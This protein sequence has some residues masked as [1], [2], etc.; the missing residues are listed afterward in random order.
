MRT[1][2]ITGATKGIGLSIAETL[3][4]STDYYVVGVGRSGADIGHLLGNERFQYVECD[5]SS[6]GFENRLKSAIPAELYGIVNNAGICK[7]HF[8]NDSSPDTFDEV[9]SVNLQAP[10]RIV[11]TLHSA[12]CDRGRIVNISS[13][14][15]Q[16]GRAGYSAYCASKFAL[17]GMTKCWAKE[18]GARGITVNAVCPGWVET[19]MGIK[20]VERLAV[21]S[22]VSFDAFYG[23]ICKP[24]ELKRFTKPAEIAEL[25]AFLLSDA[26]SGI[27]GRDWLLNTIWNQE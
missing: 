9:L 8:L 11:K 25:V 16:E 24:L 6:A 26:A 13:Q 22:G 19:E 27:T 17:I 15:G 20:D 12:L 18:L 10:Y 1:I 2:L 23:E 21:E 3:L 4:R 5:L 14:L 7:T